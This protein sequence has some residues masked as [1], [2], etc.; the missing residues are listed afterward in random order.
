MPNVR[1]NNVGGLEDRFNNIEVELSFMNTLLKTN[2]VQQLFKEMVAEDEDLGGFCAYDSLTDDGTCLPPTERHI[3]RKLSNLTNRY[4][5]SCT[6]FTFW[7][8]IRED[9]LSVHSMQ[10][11]N[12]ARE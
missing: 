3:V 7:N 11:P 6:L 9:L 2:G 10:T 1:C 12:S 5:G 4:Y 8:K